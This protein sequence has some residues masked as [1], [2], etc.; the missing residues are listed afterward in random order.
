MVFSDVAAADYTQ[1]SCTATF[2][3]LQI[4][5]MQVSYSNMLVDFLICTGQDIIYTN[6]GGNLVTN[7]RI[8]T[9][10]GV[11]IMYTQI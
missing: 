6:D 1:S 8:S 2:K 3:W 9:F 10:C 5:T 4:I 11:I 7:S